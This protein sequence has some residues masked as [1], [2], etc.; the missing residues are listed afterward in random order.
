MLQC[1]ADWSDSSS[2][3]GSLFHSSGKWV[4]TSKI[5]TSCFYVALF[6]LGNF[7]YDFY[8][9]K[10]GA[11]GDVRGSIPP[12]TGASKKHHRFPDL[13][14]MNSSYFDVPIIVFNKFGTFCYSWI[15]FCLCC[16]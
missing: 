3:A 15:F 6:D 7:L 2:S 11:G 9:G 4:E 16:V 8:F 13:R 14:G 1:L 12:V 10:P 5:L